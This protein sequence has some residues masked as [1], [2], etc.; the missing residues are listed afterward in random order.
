[1]L[2]DSSAPMFAAS[3]ITA[4]Q[5]PLGPAAIRLRKS[6]VARTFGSRRN[7]ACVIS[8][9]SWSATLSDTAI[10]FGRRSPM[11]EWNWPLRSNGELDAEAS[12]LAR[13]ANHRIDK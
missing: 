4:Q 13:P 10:S 6:A 5:S 8:H 7:S 3:I 11:A 9:T 1:M 12:R 2:L